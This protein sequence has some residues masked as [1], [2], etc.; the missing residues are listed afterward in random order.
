M[1]RLFF[2]VDGRVRIVIIGRAGCGKYGPIR[3]I[4]GPEM[5]NMDR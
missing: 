5:E 1:S 2:Y 3:K 4:I